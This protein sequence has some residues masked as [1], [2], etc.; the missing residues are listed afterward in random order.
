MVGEI[1][2]RKRCALIYGKKTT[3]KKNTKVV[4]RPELIV[5]KGK[6]QLIIKNSSISVN[7][8]IKAP[9]GVGREFIILAVV[10]IVSSFILGGLRLGN[11]L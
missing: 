9:F 5:N 10:D 2:M 11:H 7:R 3:V 6:K 1:F 8:G 4:R